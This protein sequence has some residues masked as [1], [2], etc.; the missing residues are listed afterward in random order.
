M[1]HGATIENA[2]FVLKIES[3][4]EVNCHRIRQNDN[5]VVLQHLTSQLGYRSEI[6]SLITLVPVL[7]TKL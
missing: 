3:W 7:S 4:R 6:V 5:V 2:R 1:A